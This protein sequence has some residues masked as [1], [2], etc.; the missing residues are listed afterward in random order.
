MTLENRES[1]S[2]WGLGHDHQLDSQEEVS[3]VA[4]SSGSQIASVHF[5]LEQC[6]HVQV[7]NRAPGNSKAAGAITMALRPQLSQQKFHP[8]NKSLILHICICVY[9]NTYI[10]PA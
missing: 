5:D 4:M 3:D 10:S 7:S 2:D 9:I 8:K 1:K 6:P